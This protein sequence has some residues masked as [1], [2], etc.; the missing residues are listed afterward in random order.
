[1][2]RGSGTGIG[3]LLLTLAAIG[4]SAA[5]GGVAATRLYAANPKRVLILDLFGR[6]VAPFSTTI[7][8]FRTTLARELEGR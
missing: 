8:A 4:A 7:S 6:D 2:T 5:Y 3:L 1:M